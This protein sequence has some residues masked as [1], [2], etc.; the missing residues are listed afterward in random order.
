MIVIFFNKIL[1]AEEVFTTPDFGQSDILN[2]EYPT[3]LFLSQSLKSHELPLW[4]PSVGTGFPQSSVTSGF[5]N[6]VNLALFYFLP[7]PLAFNIGFATIFATT[8]IF[9]YLFCR[10]LGLSQISSLFGS[11]VFTFSGIFATQIVHFSVIQTLSFFPL[12]IYLIELYIQK[13]K[14]YLLPLFSLTLGLQILTGFYQAILYSLIIITIYTAIKIFYLQ[15]FKNKWVFASTLALAIFAGF[16]IGA[17]QLLPSWEFTKIS[18]REKGVTQEEIKSFPYPI[19]HLAAFVSPYIFGD[20]RIGTYPHFNENWGIFWE[21]TG[22]L[23]IL[24]LLLATIAIIWGRKKYK[25]INLFLVILIVTFLLMLGKNSPTFLLYQF[26]PLSLFRVPARWIMFFTF[27]LSI[28]A[29]YGFQ[30]FQ[31]KL[32]GKIKSGNL[33]LLLLS[34]LI[35]STIDLFLFSAR[36]NLRGQ[37]AKWLATPQTAQFLKKD[38]SLFRIDTGGNQEIWNHQFLKIGWLTGAENYL[39]YLEAL[40]PNWNEVH[41]IDHVSLYAIIQSKRNQILSTVKEQN[42]SKSADGFEF[43]SASRNL[44]DLQN[45]KYIISPYHIKGRGLELVFKS[46]TQPPYFIFRNKTVLNRAFI[47]TNW[48]IAQTFDQL[49]HIIAS[50]NFDPRKTA[51]LEKIPNINFQATISSAAITKY[52][53]QDVEIKTKLNGNGI[54]VLA[55][56]FHPAW[57][58]TVDGQSVEILAANVDQ[59]AVILGSGEHL[60]KFT[61][62]PKSFKNGLAITLTSSILLLAFLIWAILKGEKLKLA[63]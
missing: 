43:K 23:G 1:T 56:S 50:S 4:D 22:Y 42:I 55:D 10:T 62:D 9:T 44:L 3:K 28:L 14:L 24:P 37:A 39:T 17:V 7:M 54:L 53:N 20:P 32:E 29:A 52:T 15:S 45:V 6:P 12:E 21:N 26:P 61:Y 63:D 35:V 40:D 34:I 30:T 27:T 18:T 49:K 41:D 59:R 8:A 48:D 38:Q 51:V 36:Y 11:V 2:I 47:V 5:F 31:N 57:K 16:L 46:Q 58:A 60:V 13:R 25:N 19:K 33:N